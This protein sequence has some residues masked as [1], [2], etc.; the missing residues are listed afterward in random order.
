[1]EREP[2]L[3]SGPWGGPDMIAYMREAMALLQAA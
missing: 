2:A 1:M 3:L